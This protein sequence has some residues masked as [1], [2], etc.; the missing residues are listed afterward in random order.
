[1]A[2]E[3]QSRIVDVEWDVDP[4]TLNPNP[5]NF[6]LHQKPQKDTMDDVFSE[7]GNIDGIK[8]SKKTR[9][10]IDGHMRVELY[11]EKQQNIP[12][13]IWLDLEDEEEERRAIL[14]FDQ[15]GDMARIDKKILADAISKTGI[16]NEMV[17]AM[18][19]KL[20]ERKKIDIKDTTTKMEASVKSPDEEVEETNIM[21]QELIDKWSVE[22]H[23]VWEVAPDCILI[24]GD[25][26]SYTVKDLVKRYSPDCL[27]TDP[28][29]G[30][31]VVGS[32]RKIGLAQ[33][34]GDIKGDL[35]PFDPKDIL[36]FGLPSIV[37]GA[38]H[39]ADRLPASPKWLVWDKKGA[40]NKSNDFADAEMAW[41]S[42]KGVVR[43]F[44][45]VWRG[46]ARAS[47]RGVQRFHP[48]QKPVEVMKWCIEE[49]LVGYDNILD[50]YAGSGSTGIAAYL[51]NRKCVLIEYDPRYVAA[52]IERFYNI[53]KQV[54]E[55]KVIQ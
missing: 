51:L 39:F 37:W 18:I 25:S 6:R 23:S 1:M 27:M 16:Q 53:Q 20:A 30:I 3:Y 52:T 21:F 26:T 22:E 24:R 11:K 45:H 50:M 19:K 32:D 17:K 4:N 33:A 8:A 44:T 46:A 49:H 15:V 9:N 35:S 5:F 36:D 7:I 38:N 48:T 29:Y 12:L 28:P 31:D 54:R 47:E 42:E 2:L 34:F 14:M 43:V 41:C 55:P 13:V 10:V 40:D